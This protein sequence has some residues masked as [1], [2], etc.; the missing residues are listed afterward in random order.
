MVIGLVIVGAVLGGFQFYS[1]AGDKPG[2]GM[3]YVMGALIYGGLL[4]LIYWMF[5]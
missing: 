4:N 3:A 1:K 2:I 5:F